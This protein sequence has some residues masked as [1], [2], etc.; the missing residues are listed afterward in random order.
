M[1]KPKINQIK[2]IFV[3][4]LFPGFLSRIKDTIPSKP[5]GLI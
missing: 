5:P 2:S 4:E 3:V 1:D